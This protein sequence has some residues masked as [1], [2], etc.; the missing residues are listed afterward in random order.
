MTGTLRT[1]L[2]GTGDVL[3][4]SMTRHGVTRYNFVA[5][6]ARTVTVAVAL[7]TDPHAFDTRTQ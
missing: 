7:L 5:V 3:R 1:P 4:V 2:L 6:T